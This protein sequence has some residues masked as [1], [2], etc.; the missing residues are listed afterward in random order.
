ML[1]ANGEYLQGNLNDIKGLIQPYEPE[2]CTHNWYNYNLRLDFDA[3]GITDDKVR[4]RDAV[5]AAIAAEGV[6][7]MVWQRFILPKMTVFKAKNA[8]GNGFPWSIPGL[9]T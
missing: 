2:D 6:G 4:F 5:C 1:R 3:L 8:Y 7:C 9:H